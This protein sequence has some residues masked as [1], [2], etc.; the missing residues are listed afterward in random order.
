MTLQ[1][2]IQ[3]LLAQLQSAEVVLTRHGA[4]LDLLIR[5]RAAISD[6][7]TDLE[8][9]TVTSDALATVIAA[10]HHVLAW[11]ATPPL[12]A[13]LPTSI[14]QIAHLRRRLFAALDRV[15]SI[16]AA[17]IELCVTIGCVIQ[18]ATGLL[19]REAATAVELVLWLTEA[20]DVLNRVAS[21]DT[22]ERE[23]A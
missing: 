10:R 12:H 15:V 20:N 13:L 2:H 16:A 7:Q 1:E 3:L 18:E 22:A 17:S 6:V 9:H 8:A 5:L 19:A 4:P 23:V 21:Y 14:Q 11:A